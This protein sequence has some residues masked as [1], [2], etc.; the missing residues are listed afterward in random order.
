MKKRKKGQHMNTTQLSRPN[1]Q[2]LTPYQSAR[3]LG[4]NGTIWLNANEAPLSP[5]FPV[6]T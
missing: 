6:K 5:N 3:K 4:G 2:A 1:V